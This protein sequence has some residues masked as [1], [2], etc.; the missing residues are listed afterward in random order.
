MKILLENFPA[1]DSVAYTPG[2]EVSGRIRFQVDAKETY[3][4]LGYQVN[5]VISQ[6]A[7][8][9]TLLFHS[10]KLGTN[11]TLEA[12]EEKVFDVSFIVPEY[13]AYRG[14]QFS[15]QPQFRAYAFVAGK[16][17]SVLARKFSQTYATY[18]DFDYYPVSV[19]RP[20]TRTVNMVNT[21]THEGWTIGLILLG[22]SL[23][24]LYTL[25]HALAILGGLAV[26][27]MGFRHLLAYDQAF[28][29]SSPEVGLLSQNK[30]HFVVSLKG[31]FPKEIVSKV[32][33][34]YYVQESITGQPDDSNTNSL[35]AKYLEPEQTV[36]LKNQ[37]SA[38][39]EHQYLPFPN[40]L[41]SRTFN[42]TWVY[43]I[44]ATL[45]DG[46]EIRWEGNLV[47]Q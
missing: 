40:K 24:I 26:I 15:F 5:T 33:A 3:S 47:P 20:F 45:Q 14:E 10:A 37:S 22:M 42:L 17:N 38:L 43:V 36:T 35:K 13:P 30:S 31:Y 1:P 2:T 25:H 8:K 9:K 4:S 23:F 41:P 44:K 12:G 27:Y 7:T 18:A 39:I 34:Y 28:Q 11:I 19:R 6:G 29:I 46:G 16:G 32:T 21:F